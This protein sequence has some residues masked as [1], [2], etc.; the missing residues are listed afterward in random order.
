MTDWHYLLFDPFGNAK[1]KTAVFSVVF[2]PLEAIVIEVS[3]FVSLFD[4]N[5]IEN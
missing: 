4:S 3:A 1:S 2:L 5:K